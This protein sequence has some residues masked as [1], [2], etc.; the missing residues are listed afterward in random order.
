MA[1]IKEEQIQEIRRRAK[2]E[3]IIGQY[4]PIEKKGRSLK[5]ICPFH[6]DHSPSLSISTDKQIFK[7][8]VCGTG[9]NVFQFVEKYEKISFQE[10]VIKV[11]QMIHYPLDVELEPS[12][13]PVNSKYLPLY[14]V[15]NESIAY[16]QFQLDSVDGIQ[17][18]EYLH[19]RGI[20]DDQI[21]KFQLGYLP[22]T[23]RLHEFLSKKG[24]SDEVMIRTN[25]AVVN[26]YGLH[27]VMSSRLTIPIHDIDG[28]PVGFT[29]R[30]MDPRDDR[31]YI[32][33]SETEI[34]S[35]GKLIYNYHRARQECKRQQETIVVEGPMDLFAFDKAGIHHV[36]ATLGTACTTEQMQLI[37]KLSMKIILCYDGDMAGQHAIYKAGKI[38]LS[39]GMTVFV[40]NNKTGKDPDEIINMYGKDEL[41]MIVKK[42]MVWLEFVHQYHLTHYDL[43]N[44]NSKREYVSIMMNEIQMIQDTFDRDYFMNQLVQETGFDFIQLKSLIPQEK[45]SL[46]HP[47]LIKR[48]RFSQMDGERKAQYEIVSQ[49]L[50]SQEAYRRFK[51]ELGF[52]VDDDC[53]AIVIELMEYYRTHQTMELADFLNCLEEERLQQLILDIT[54]SE[55]FVQE[56]NMDVLLGAMQKMKDCL[57]RRQVEQLK[58]EMHTIQDPVLKTKMVEQYIQLLKKTKKEK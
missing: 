53:Q 26:E 47:T 29:A 43:N 11:A 16:S 55:L 36:V 14:Q 9:G 1:F 56:P 18:K 37:K 31:K 48:S 25:L 57:V 15:L 13:K 58:R 46:N 38:A 49:L 22:R 20:T 8:F 24:F 6:D 52:L 4:L 2:I 5:C 10:A 41:I 45:K 30:T 33:T 7:C 51:D 23:H 39:M 17:V 40:A 35:K 21:T 19:K 3:E 28:N 27:D 44:Y 32:N 34:Y 54:E 42:P 12:K 50:L